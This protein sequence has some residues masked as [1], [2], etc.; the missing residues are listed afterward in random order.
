MLET[1]LEIKR[2]KPTVERSKVEE[3]CSTFEPIGRL[4]KLYLFFFLLQNF[5]LK[6]DSFIST[7]WNRLIMLRLVCH[8]G[9]RLFSTHFSPSEVSVGE[10]LSSEL[11]R[12][13]GLKQS[14]YTREKLNSEL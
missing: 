4:I 1:F 2:T 5:A 11:Q 7:H 10:E 13:I 3:I 9:C 14:R 6:S 12:L 8:R